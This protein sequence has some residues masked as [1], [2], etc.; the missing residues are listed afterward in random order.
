MKRVKM[1]E[2]ALRQERYAV[3]IVSVGCYHG[4]NFCILGK[5]MLV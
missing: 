1:L 4:G 2:Y 3:M 5:G